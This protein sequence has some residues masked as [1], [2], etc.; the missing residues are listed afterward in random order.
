MLLEETVAQ[1]KH[2]HPPFQL[3][4]SETAASPFGVAR[5]LAAERLQQPPD[6]A[7]SEHLLES[8]R[9]QLSVGGRQRLLSP[10]HRSQKSQDAPPPPTENHGR[11]QVLLPP[12]LFNY[13]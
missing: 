12:P 11:P 13:G 3:V 7:A 9:P 6:L 5:A 8:K 2:S 4:A 10:G 1:E